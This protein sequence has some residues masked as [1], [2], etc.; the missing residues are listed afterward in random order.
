MSHIGDTVKNRRISLGQSRG[1]LATRLHTTANIVADIERGVRQP[2]ADTINRLARALGVDPAELTSPARVARDGV[3]ATAR[4]VATVSS[5]AVA[6]DGFERMPVVTAPVATGPRP[7][8]RAGAFPDL[9]DAPTEAVPVVGRQPP[10]VIP[11]VPPAQPTAATEP[12]P[13]AY[14]SLQRFMATVFDRD[15]SYLFWIRTVLT[16]VMLLVGFR[17]LAWAVPALFDALG[18]ILGTIESTNPTPTTIPG[19]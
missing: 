9:I 3:P 17:V 2:D 10:L 15:R 11:L 4:T 6:G 16:I 7:G 1:Q 12:V 8:S 14:G 13:R 19:N 5:A 18:D